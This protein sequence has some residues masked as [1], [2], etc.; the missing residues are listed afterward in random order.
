MDG[1]ISMAFNGLYTGGLKNCIL[2]WCL[3]PTLSHLQHI[4]QKQLQEI[5]FN[6]MSLK[7]FYCFI[8]KE[9]NRHIKVKS[10]CN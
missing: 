6:Y 2:I 8:C 4:S 9:I 5:F 3:V 10:Q 7:H 1:Y